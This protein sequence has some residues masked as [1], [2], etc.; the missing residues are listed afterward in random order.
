[1]FAADLSRALTIDHTIDFLSVT[2]YRGRASTGRVRVTQ[3]VEL[4]LHGRDVLIVEDI[5]DT[6][7]T[8]DRVLEVVR[9]Q[10]P[11]SIRVA[12][13][14]DKPVRRVAPVRPDYVGFEI[15]DQ[16]V[17]GYGLDLDS[18]YRGLPYIAAVESEIAAGAAVAQVPARRADERA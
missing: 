8:L 14:L 3:D 7:R 15:G 18:K 12:A 17:A 5:V 2:S 10:A 13:L 9:A 16:F 1:M 4:E 11:A 6:G